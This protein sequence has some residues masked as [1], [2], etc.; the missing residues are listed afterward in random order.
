M[1]RWNRLLYAPRS[2]HA[3]N[4]MVFRTWEEDPRNTKHST[5]NRQSMSWLRT[6]GLNTNG[7]AAKVMIFAGLGP[8]TFGTFGKIQVG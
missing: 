8:G 3:R 5:I 1:Q 7:A 4:V 2:G 6:N